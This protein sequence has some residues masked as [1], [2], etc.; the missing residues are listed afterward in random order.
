MSWF[1]FETAYKTDTA[2]MPNIAKRL[3][4]AHQRGVNM[5]IVL[6]NNIER[7]KD[8]SNSE[9]RPYQMLAQ[10]LG[11]DDDKSSYIVHCEPHK[12][13]IGMRKIYKKMYAYNHNKFRISSKIVMNG[14]SAVSDVVFQSS[15][16]LGTWDADESWNN[17]VTWSGSA[18]YA[19][20]LGPGDNDYYWVGD[21]VDEYKT[22]FF[23][24]KE[25]NGNLNQA[26]TDTVVNILKP[27]N[28]SYVGEDGEKHQTDI[29][30]LMWAFNRV[31]VAEQ[32]V[33]LVRDGCWVDIAY[34]NMNDNVKSAL[35][36]VKGQSIGL[37]HC[38]VKHDGRN[39]R[40]H[41]KYMVIDGAYDDDQISRVYA[42]SHNY[43]M[44]SLRNADESLVRIR[45]ADIH[46]AYQ[47]KNFYKV[48]DTC[49]G[50]IKPGGI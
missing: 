44:S 21:S 13:C 23:P 42:G 22:H 36:K 37:T 6:H 29:G 20:R 5:R 14:G 12:G 50:K 32:L 7:G 3:V 33:K 2:D 38:G 35:A 18:S 46:S 17:A 10:E 43:A 24:R 25:T 49:S 45:N 1:E 28:C 31:A 30:I 11:T 48:R 27:V 41:S 19:N 16:N 40:L 9:A 15:A 39:L 8:D 26:S 4:K 47:H 34:A